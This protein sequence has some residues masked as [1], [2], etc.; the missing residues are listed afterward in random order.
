MNRRKFLQLASAAGL[1][2]SMR[3]FGQTSSLGFEPWKPGMLDIHH[4]AYGRGNSTFIMCPDGT[5]FL[6]DA[7]V[8]TDSTK[9]SCA[10]KP[11]AR[12]R[13]GEWIAS[14]A[15]RQMK[16]AGRKELDYALITHIHPD[17]LGDPTENT[18]SSSKGDYKLT[19][20]TDVDAQLP[21]LK[22]IDRGYPDYS[23]PTP[24]RT[25][26]AE[27]YEA[28]VKSRQR[29][30]EPT[31]RIKVGSPTQIRLVQHPDKYS[32]FVVRNLA[33]NGEVWTGVGEQTQKTFPDLNTL[34]KQDYPNENMCS[35]ALRLSYGKF[36]YFAGGDLTTTTED[37]AAEPWRDIETAA[38]KAAG[39]VEV[40][41]AD[42]HAY[43]D[44]VGP[45]FV[46]ELRPQAF[47]IPAWYVNH[48][49]TLPLRR[50]FSRKLYPGDRDV[51]ATC[52][53][54]ENRVYNG[55]F[56]SKMKSFDGH[57]VVRVAPGGET[58]QIMVTD[59]S[60]DSDRVKLVSGPYHS[61]ERLKS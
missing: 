47:I 32:N 19:G 38:A 60:D 26:F 3:G 15:T 13:P 39:P 4:L 34:N 56:N 29:L 2:S 59:N 17:H 42:H 16:S 30:G 20:I 14:Y 31:E 23:Y 9:V 50:M 52:T 58:F 48:P 8:T 21:I 36:D 12:V 43:L 35:I 61:S 28:Y 54:E 55:Q 6:I 46:R 41:I 57:V 37:D 33:G 53:M 25:D 5:T 44:A 45:N 24:W 10:Q 11:D 27:N 7:G 49:A 1:M 22:L 51:F 18:A 40:A